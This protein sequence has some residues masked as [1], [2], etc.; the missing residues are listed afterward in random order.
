[1]YRL[2][3]VDA[4]MFTYLPSADILSAK[5]PPEEFAL[6]MTFIMVVSEW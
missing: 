2:Y 1:M 3:R 4:W 5:S 6:D